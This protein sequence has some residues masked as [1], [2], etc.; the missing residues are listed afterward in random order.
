M[1]KEG[2]DFSIILELV[3]KQ[4]NNVAQSNLLV[5]GTGNDA[6]MPW[7]EVEKISQTNTTTDHQP[8][9]N[10]APNSC[11]LPFNHAFDAAA[12]AHPLLHKIFAPPSESSGS[13]LPL[14]M[15]K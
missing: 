3:G 2:I 10:T 8:N 11:E 14:T 12:D 6:A 1:E 4:Y 15:T 9:K 7:H 5:P 13:F